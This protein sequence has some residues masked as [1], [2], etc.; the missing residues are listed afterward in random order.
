MLA[1]D[2]THARIF[3]VSLQSA[4]LKTLNIPL[5]ERP[6][7]ILYDPVNKF[8]YW[9][10]LAGKVLRSSLDG[11]NIVTIYS[12]GNCFVFNGYNR[13]YNMNYALGLDKSKKCF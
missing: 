1:A 9:T 13:Y 12:S 10:E 7:E 5:V 8:L 2:F 6:V 3:Q 11:R 4:N